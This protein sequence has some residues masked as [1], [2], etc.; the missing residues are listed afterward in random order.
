MNVEGSQA[1]QAPTPYS[2]GSPAG[3]RGAS[4]YCREGIRGGLISAHWDGDFPRYVWIRK[5]DTVFEARLVNQ[6][7]G[8]YKGWE[9]KPEEYPEALR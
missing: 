7:S 3:G 4:G 9:L 5:E 1:T 8:A 6:D 2:D